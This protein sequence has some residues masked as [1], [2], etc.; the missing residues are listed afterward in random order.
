MSDKPTTIVTCTNKEYVPSVDEKCDGCGT[1]IKLS[2]SLKEEL[3]GES[4]ILLCQLCSDLRGDAI[5]R[6]TMTRRQYAEL[7]ELFGSDRVDE[8]LLFVGATLEDQE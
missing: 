1:D 7:S 2:I 4:V 6:P 5:P 8:L 3:E